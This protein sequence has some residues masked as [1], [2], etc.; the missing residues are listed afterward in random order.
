[1]VPLDPFG[2]R[3][4]LDEIVFRWYQSLASRLWPWLDRTTEPEPLPPVQPLPPRQAGGEATTKTQL[5][6]LAARARP[7]PASQAPRIRVLLRVQLPSEAWPCG[8]GASRPPLVTSME[9]ELQT[10]VNL[11][12]VLMNRE[13]LYAIVAVLGVSI[14]GCACVLTYSFTNYSKMKRNAEEVRNY[15]ASRA[16]LVHERSGTKQAGVSKVALAAS[17]TDKASVLAVPAKEAKVEMGK[18]QGP[19][20][21]GNDTFVSQTAIGASAAVTT[22]EA[23]GTTGGDE[24]LSSVDQGG[25][26]G[27]ET[28]AVAEAVANSAPVV[29]SMMS[30]S[31]SWNA[32]EHGSAEAT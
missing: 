18:Q 2:R 26:S 28:V 13:G 12:V 27:G 11:P 7:G 8:C 22:L 1:M 10:Q 16:K 23:S 29:Y 25:G 30:A 19:P 9:P 17:A 15:M 14:L 21:D 31:V 4:R 32:T 6:R 5:E 24:Q 20:I 3:F